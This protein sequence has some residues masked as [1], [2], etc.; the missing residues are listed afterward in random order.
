MKEEKRGHKAA[1]AL[2]C[3]PSQTELL[4]CDVE[5]ACATEKVIRALMPRVV[6]LTVIIVARNMKITDGKVCESDG[7]DPYMKTSF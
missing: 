7:A 1:L 4:S 6:A 3:T 2:P 5:R